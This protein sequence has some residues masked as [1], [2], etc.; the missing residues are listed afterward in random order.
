MAKLK[1]RKDGRYQRKVTLSNG[2]QKIVYGRT[3]AELAA[4]EAAL[5]GDDSAGLVVGDHTLVGEWAK[6]WLTTY[7]CKLRANTVKMY[8]DSYNNH[9]MDQLGNM[10]LRA[11]RPVH[12]QAC[13]TLISD[14]SESL[15]HKVLITLNQLFKTAKDNSLIARNPADGIT[16]TPHA[17]PKKKKWLTPEETDQLMHTTMDPRATAFCALC[18]YCGL[19]K[20]EALGL[21]WTDIEGGALTVR[22]AVTFL[23]NQP[24]PV[25]ELKTDAAS[26]SI[27]IPGPLREVL[28]NT[29]HLGQY[30]VTA[31]GGGEMTRS[32][33]TR[34]WNKVRAAVPFHVTPHML[35]HT[36]ATMLY[37]AN[38]DLRTAQH[39]LGHSSIQV[40]ADI[41][42]HIQQ[43]DNLKAGGQID[44]YLTENPA[45]DAKSSQKVV[46][47]ITA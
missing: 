15:Q 23:T 34:L 27:P 10:E 37:H 31:A 32:A 16:T 7:K 47:F 1:K 9:I 40:T 14:K 25:Q 46:N 41:Y 3:L 45:S 42:T 38:V 5:R 17:K 13:M 22:R 21:Q 12:V 19:R 44:Q 11:V 8:R 39:L 43:E 2:K 26:R 35:R 4:A 18:L 28:L 29:P 6:I 36:Y 24:D 20:E 30:I 33:F